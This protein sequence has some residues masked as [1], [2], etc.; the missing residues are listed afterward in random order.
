V[1]DAQ[2]LRELVALA[3]E[4]GLEVRMVRGAPVGE[5][6]PAARSAVCRV[7]GETWVVL[8]GADAV[9]DRIEVVAQALR[10][11]AAPWLEGRYLPPLVRARI[12]G[13]T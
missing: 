1:T 6:E 2:L 13:D 3:E 9:E 12:S 4:A 5:G 10:D 11:H 7:R 8:S